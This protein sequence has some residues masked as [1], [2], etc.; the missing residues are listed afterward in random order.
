MVLGVGP[1]HVDPVVAVEVRIDRQPHEAGLM[2]LQGLDGQEFVVLV[3]DDPQQATGLLRDDHRTVGQELEIPTAKELIA[4]QPNREAAVTEAIADVVAPIR[5]VGHGLETF[6]GRD[7]VLRV[8]AL[9]GFEELELPDLAFERLS[10]AAVDRAASRQV[11]GEAVNPV[12][13]RA[14]ESQR[15]GQRGEH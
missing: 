10:A 5:D 4:E 13:A 6:G 3:A 11:V 1:E 15:Q 9:A 7:A 8:P 14:A 12:V 2:G